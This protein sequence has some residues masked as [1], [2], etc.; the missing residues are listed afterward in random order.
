MGLP[1]YI[2]PVKSD[3]RNKISASSSCHTHGAN[4]VRR[5][6]RSTEA[7]VESR[8]RAI[9]TALTA[10]TSPQLEDVTESQRA[11]N[12]Q[13][14]HRSE[15]TQQ[16]TERRHLQNSQW[17][18]TYL[19]RPREASSSTSNLSRSQETTTLDVA[20]PGRDSLLRRF[21]ERLRAH[22]QS[23]DSSNQRREG[24]TADTTSGASSSVSSHVTPA[25]VTIGSVPS[26][27][28]LPA[29]N[30]HVA[31][32]RGSAGLRDEQRLWY[33]YA[34]SRSRNRA[35]T[36]PGEQNRH[37]ETGAVLASAI[38]NNVGSSAEEDRRDITATQD[39][40]LASSELLSTRSN[41]PSHRHPHTTAEH[42]VA[43]GS[44]TGSD[45]ESSSAGVRQSQSATRRASSL[46]SVMVVMLNASATSTRPNVGWSDD[47]GT[48]SRSF[49]SSQ[50]RVFGDTRQ[51]PNADGHSLTNHGWMDGFPDMNGDWHTPQRDNNRRV[52]SPPP[53]TD[54]WAFPD[55]PLDGLGD[56]RRS[57]SPNSDHGWNTL[58]TA[59]TPD[60]QPSSVGAPSAFTSSARAAP[61]EGRTTWLSSPQPTVSAT[62]TPS[63]TGSLSAAQN[64]DDSENGVNHYIPPPVLLEAP[65]A[66]FTEN[67]ILPVGNFTGLA[68]ARTY[69][70]IRSPN[71]LGPAGAVSAE[72]S[73]VVSDNGVDG[74]A[75]Y[76]DS[77]MDDGLQTDGEDE[78][79]GC[80]EDEELAAEVRAIFTGT[81]GRSP[82]EGLRLLRLTLAGGAS[83]GESFQSH[84]S[85]NSNNS[86][87][88]DT[89]DLLGIGGMQHIVRSLAR[90]EDIPDE[91]WAEAGLSRT[92]AR[93]ASSLR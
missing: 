16:S 93:E 6:R 11:L 37:G 32:T 54:D 28:L 21:Y 33:D 22:E 50:S 26:A 55:G 77:E 10:T 65:L 2:A 61:T 38:S 36:E 8:R 17:P 90:R 35:T 81:A 86:T 69:Q 56:R 52:R 7:L 83:A 23:G 48:P 29:A 78:D 45:G 13:Q 68:S 74:E 73:A 80:D 66:W 44:A 71:S 79:V 76:E 20:H 60:P 67:P 85:N 12:R 31:A 84:N 82:M 43:E 25:S 9:M 1:L 42:Y 3:L 63:D 30:A 40:G 24:N 15:E 18:E 19:A 72:E 4:R 89:L 70:H 57:L 53:Q 46:R 51:F 64:R 41:S 34:I 59:L 5:V 87:S 47:V 49:E 27:T 58:L 92:L 88:Q 91:W 62:Q 75:T 39:T 14:Q